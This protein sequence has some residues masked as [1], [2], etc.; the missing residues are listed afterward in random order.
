MNFCWIC[1]SS[2]ATFSPIALIS[3]KASFFSFI[4]YKWSRLMN[5]LLRDFRVFLRLSFRSKKRDHSCLGPL[6]SIEG[7]FKNLLFTNV[8]MELFESVSSYFS[9]I[10]EKSKKMRNCCKSKSLLKK[11]IVLSCKLVSLRSSLTSFKSIF[12]TVWLLFLLSF[13]VLRSSRN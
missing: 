13:C 3:S 4:S 10:L 9:S 5:F 1:F 12:C 2:L 7:G 6:T 11:F 8:C